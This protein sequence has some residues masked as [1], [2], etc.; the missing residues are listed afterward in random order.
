M[1]NEEN[2]TITEGRDLAEDFAKQFIN[3]TTIKE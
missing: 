2:I 1:S 3:L